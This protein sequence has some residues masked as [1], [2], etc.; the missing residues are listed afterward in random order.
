M[1]QNV[2]IFHGTLEMIW[3][4]WHRARYAALVLCRA[5]Q[6]LEARLI[7]CSASNSILSEQTRTFPD[8]L[9]ELRENYR[10]AQAAEGLALAEMKEL[11]DSIAI[12]KARTP[13]DVVLKLEMAVGSEFEIEDSSVFPLPQL[14]SALRDLKS[15]TLHPTIHRKRATTRSDVSQ[16][17]NAAIQQISEQ[18]L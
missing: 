6:R 3:S 4:K 8:P 13:V 12:V 9:Q 16:Y 17:W 11:Q 14:T 7:R 18:S 2:G 10:I 15:M 1:P 5:Q